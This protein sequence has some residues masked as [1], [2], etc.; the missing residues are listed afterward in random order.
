[1]GLGLWVAPLLALVARRGG[2]SLHVQAYHFFTR[3]ALVTFGGAY[4]V[5]S[6]VNRAAV[7]AFGWVS[8]AQAIDGLALAE[9]TPGPLIMVLQFIGFLA[10]W[11]HPEG[12]AP[13]AGAALA[14]AATTYATFLPCFLFIFLGA[15]YVERLRGERRLNAA[16][17]AV[18]AAVVGVVLDL[19]LVFGEAVV[20]PQGWGAPPGAF[21][22][23]VALAALLALALR[24]DILWV[25]LAAGALGVV[26]LLVG[27]AP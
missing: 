18:T 19:G 2:E 6:Y 26:R 20:F 3:A 8:A 5:L 25:V 13:A 21:A 24:A 1:V 27:G 15:P 7:D 4:A 12:L 9:T 17:A 10:G 23:A 11:N 16:L 22:A 14:A